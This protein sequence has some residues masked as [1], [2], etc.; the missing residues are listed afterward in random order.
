M[1][2]N[3]RPVTITKTKV[4]QGQ[5]Q[6]E[7]HSQSRPKQDASITLLG[8][9]RLNDKLGI[10]FETASPA[11][12]GDAVRSNKFWIKIHMWFRSHF[13]YNYKVDLWLYVT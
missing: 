3:M 10:L 4:A 11:A 2:W 7:N 5:N 12:S 9:W 8:R 13:L 6:T 1:N